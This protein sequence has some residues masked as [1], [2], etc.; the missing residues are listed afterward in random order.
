MNATIKHYLG[1]IFRDITS[2]GSAVFYGAVCLVV[3][4][5]GSVTLFWNLLAGF[6]FTGVVIT[7]VRLVYF[8]PRPHKQVYKN[9]IEKINASSFPSW[10]SARV[11]YIVFV[12]IGVSRVF[13]IVL[14]S[15]A[16][17]VAYSRIY[18]KKHDWCDVIFGIGLGYLSYL[19]ITF[20]LF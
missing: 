15:L 1:E 11:F 14:L 7:V 8:K 9:W 13:D 20:F 5:Y 19:L 16:G 17:L 3:L 10:H 4:A 6:F 18:L 2:L 12:F